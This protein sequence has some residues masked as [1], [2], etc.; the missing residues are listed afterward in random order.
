MRPRWHRRGFGVDATTGLVTWTP[1]SAQLG[2]QIIE[3]QVTDTTGRSAFQAFR[4]DVRP[5]NTAPVFQNAAP[6]SVSAGGTYRFTTE[7]IDAEDAV[8]Y[9]LVAAPAGMAIGPVS[10]RIVW[11]TDLA[12]LGDHPVTIRATDE[13]GLSTDQPYTLSVT[14]DVT[15]PLVNVRL[16][17]YLIDLGESVVVRVRATDDVQLSS[18]SLSIDGVLQTLD[19]NNEF[20]FTPGAWRFAQY[21][22]HGH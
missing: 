13:R 1:T 4:V 14:P 10:G 6:T 2:E 16:S 19:A 3:L 17:D 18:V 12:D 9:S 20:V 7:A 5:A 22:R 21:R 15:A 11:S 8:T